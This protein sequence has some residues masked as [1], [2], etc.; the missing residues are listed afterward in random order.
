MDYFL[1]S[2]NLIYANVL[3]NNLWNWIHIIKKIMALH[4]II[5]FIE[6]DEFHVIYDKFVTFVIFYQTDF[7]LKV[8]IKLIKIINTK[9][10]LL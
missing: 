3:Y 5:F 8:L 6:K 2:L 1:N 9:Q 4:N 10:L 7:N